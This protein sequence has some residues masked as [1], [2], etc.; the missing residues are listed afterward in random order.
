MGKHS[1]SVAAARQRPLVQVLAALAVVVVALVAYA[2]VFRPFSSPRGGSGEDG[3]MIVG[4]VAGMPAS[5]EYVGLILKDNA[6]IADVL[7]RH[8][9]PGAIPTGGNT[10]VVDV[11]DSDGSEIIDALLEDAAVHDAGRVFDSQESAETST[12][13]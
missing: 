5:D 10:F 9:L 7:D 6:E 2:L 4:E 13:P 12:A 1:R 3:G 8:H 11:G